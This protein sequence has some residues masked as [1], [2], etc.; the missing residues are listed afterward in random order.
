MATLRMTFIEVDYQFIPTFYKLQGVGED[1]T[2]NTYSYNVSRVTLDFPF[3]H[4]AFLY[5]DRKIDFSGMADNELKKVK[6]VGAMITI[7]NHKDH[8]TNISM[9]S[10]ALQCVTWGHHVLANLDKL[11]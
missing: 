8:T 11:V 9:D 7:T 2:E 1:P 10:N 5:C 6:G 4:A 3:F